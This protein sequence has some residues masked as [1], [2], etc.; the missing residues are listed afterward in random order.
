MGRAFENRSDQFLTSARSNLASINQRWPT[1]NASGNAVINLVQNQRYYFELLYKEGSGGENTGVT[2]KKASDPDPAIGD[3]E[4]QGK[5]PQRDLDERFD[6]Q[7]ATL[8][9]DRIGRIDSQL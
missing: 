7:K 8:E 5:F 3:P 2:W 6:I 9:S 1:T 4:I